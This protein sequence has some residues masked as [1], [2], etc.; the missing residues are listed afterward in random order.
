LFQNLILSTKN[1]HKVNEIRD[2][3]RPLGITARSFQELGD[4]P[5]VEEDGDTLEANA[6]K[7]A[8]A[9]HE[10]YGMPCLA[11][12]TGLMVDALNGAPGVHSARYCGV[13]H[14][15]AANNTKLLNE[16]S[17][18]PW[19]KRTA[20]F[21]TVLALVDE[22]GSVFTVNGSVE[23]IIHTEL[24]GVQGFGYDPLFYIPEMKK[25]MAELTL[26]EKNIISHRARAMDNF[27][28]FMK[29]RFSLA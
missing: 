10:K 26:Q 19:E 18:I 8:R 12:D 15:F 24:K 29:T 27:I 22:D 14:D 28:E 2:K 5:D 13:E 6:I 17:H 21:I 16:L 9:F 20:R 3:L 23:G 11:D 25:T 7:K 1:E 4:A